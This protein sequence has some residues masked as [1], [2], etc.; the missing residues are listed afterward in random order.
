[1]Y[2]SLSPCNTNTIHLQVSLNYAIFYNVKH[3]VVAESCIVYMCIVCVALC[4]LFKQLNRKLFLSYALIRLVWFWNGFGH[5]RVLFRRQ[6]EKQRETVAREAAKR[7]G[8]R[9]QHQK[10]TPN[11]FLFFSLSRT[12]LYIN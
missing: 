7:G 2:I 4:V 12:L 6:G 10:R 8:G 5:A 1:M 11:Y 9:K 3:E